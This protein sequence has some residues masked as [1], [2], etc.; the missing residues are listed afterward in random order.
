MEKR[1]VLGGGGG[2]GVIVGITVAL[3][4]VLGGLY[5]TGQLS[6]VGTGG[7]SA[8]VT[9]AVPQAEPQVAEQPVSQGEEAANAP[10]PA[11]TVDTEASKAEA[12]AVAAPPPPE[13]ETA[14]AEPAQT[15]PEASETVPS[16]PVVEAEEPA[17]T[18]ASG[19]DAPAPTSP[20]SIDIVR[21][22]PD[23]SAVIAGR[24]DPGMA[25]SVLLDDVSI[26]TQEADPDGNFVFLL[27][28][29][30]SA[31]ARVLT[32]RADGDDGPLT[33][34]ADVI[35]TPQAPIAMAE[36]APVA[37]A[38]APVAATEATPPPVQVDATDA[39]LPEASDAPA[40]VADTT[41]ASLPVAEG[42]PAAPQPEETE[43]QIADG[44]SEAPEEN[45]AVTEPQVAEAASDP[46]TDSPTPPATSSAP[47]AEAMPE[48]EVT[49]TAQAA[50]TAP[51]AVLVSRPGGIEVIQPSRAAAEAPEGDFV[52]LDSISYDAG[53]QVLLT[54]RASPNGRLRVY[55]DNDEV[56]L[57][58][59]GD[60]GRWQ[61]NLRDTD[62]GIYTLRLDRVNAAGQVI[63]RIESPFQRESRA[64]LDAASE[65]TDAP[66]YAVTVQPGNTLWG[67]S[68][69]RYGEGPLYVKVFEAN[70]DQIR[71]PDL[72]YPGQVFALPE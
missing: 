53:G 66:V 24:A 44:A 43:I 50:P 19:T 20:P 55:L 11:E 40:A 6:P 1:S 9:G 23:G 28:I 57:T 62:A 12:D 67:I 48:P 17:V 68:R 42:Q 61:T 38:E 22:D 59:V 7:D 27:D 8:V 49:I 21:V 34:E 14:Q 33:A 69:A 41:E 56:V 58:D 65:G 30:A 47:A 10:A 15:D 63:A 60:D 37:Q 71:D 13:P 35:L 36:A 70:R 29:G 2:G 16:G 54:G 39:Q 26:A 31:E 3:V 5:A 32:V 64:A 46:V 45:S 18:A 4:V 25:V 51:Q 72:I 52:A